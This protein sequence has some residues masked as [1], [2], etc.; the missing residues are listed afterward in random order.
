MHDRRGSMT[1]VD[2]LLVLPR[3]WQ[4]D[5]YY[6]SSGMKLSMV[7]IAAVDVILIDSD[8]SDTR[9]PPDFDEV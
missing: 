1:I 2:L 7:S 6:R 9:C 8:D 4:P 5:C 3:F